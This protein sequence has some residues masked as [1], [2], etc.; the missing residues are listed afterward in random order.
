MSVDRAR[1][2]KL[3]RFV[4][5]WIEMEPDVVLTDAVLDNNIKRAVY[6][7]NAMAFSQEEI[8]AAKTD[9]TYIHQVYCPT[10]Q[11]LLDDYDGRKW[12]TEKKENGDINEKFWERYKTYLIDVKKF[13][14]NVVTTLSKETLEKDIMNYLGDPDSSKG[15]L[16]RGLV[17][18]DVQSGKTSTYIGLMCKAADAGYKVF[19]LLTGTIE[20]LRRQTQERVEEGFIGFNMSAERDDEKRVGVGL[21]NKPIFAMSMTSRKGDFTGDSNQ[22]AVLLRNNDAVVFVIKKNT[23][24]LQKLIDWLRTINADRLTGKIDEPML[25]IDDEADNAS[26]N[27]SKSK[28]DPTKINKLIREMANLFTKS[29]YVGFTATPYANVFIDPITTE[30]MLNH[31]LFPEDFIYAL[32]TPSDYIGPQQTFNPEGK[33]YGQ[34]I[35]IHDAGNTEEDGWPFYFKHKKDW[36]DSLPESLTDAI[37]TFYLAN[38]IRDIRG[39]QTK[40]RSMLVNISRFVRVQYYIKSHIETIH[41]E[42]YRAIKFNLNP[43]N[44]EESLKDPVLG[45]IYA[46]WL[47]QYENTGIEWKQIAKVLYK[48]VEEIQIK[49]VNSTTKKDKLVYEEDN[50]IRVIAIGGLALSR[51]L[52]LEGL[53]VSYFYRN[54]ATYDVL[55]QMGRWFGYRR[56]YDDLFRIWTHPD[57]ARWYAEIAESTEILKKDMETMHD[58]EMKPKQFGIRVRNDCKEL[59]ITSPNKRRNTRDVYEFSGYAG[60]LCET[61]YLCSDAVSNR[62]N[63]VTIKAFTEDNIDVGKTFEQLRGSGLHY[64][65]QNVEKSK[66]IR[67]IRQLNFSKYNS[68]FDKEQIIDYISNEP[69]SYIDLW[70]IAFLDGSVKTKNKEVVIRERTIYKIERNNCTTEDDRLRIGRRGKMG[71]TA[72]G[73]IGIVPFNG[74]TVASIIDEAKE[75]FKAAYRLA[76]GSEFAEGREYPADTWFK[77]VKD[78]KP[79]ILVYFIDV[80][81]DNNSNAIKAYKAQM[82]DSDGFEVPSVGLAIGFPS[83]DK[84]IISSKKMYKANA[85]YNYFEQEEAELE[86]EEE[87]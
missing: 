61:P 22:I 20:S 1:V 51:G 36:E 75:K 43:Q 73:K 58:N 18:G 72:D 44:T 77:F 79:I 42:A 15:F 8:D 16:K 38:A 5:A 81:S 32:P 27:T 86:M 55:M 35:P 69:D 83:N 6:M 87:E 66:I 11:S 10:G 68:N 80:N 25:L 50:P 21:D 23:N 85:V 56:G 14:P 82:T 29:N 70:D 84:A 28:E 64:V 48:A 60:R 67:L 2:E 47:K 78:R 26:I 13:P 39:Q 4:N 63:F 57:S 30:D 59:Q 74:K 3:V 54:T 40:H 31:D 76:N 46:N 53:T 37:Y 52:T 12:Y 7:F 41:N 33:Y 62:E 19:I 65:L 24:V 49:V 45:R 71:G 34:L 17:I 9:L